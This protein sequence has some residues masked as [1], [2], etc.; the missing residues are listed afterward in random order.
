MTT[1][2]LAPRHRSTTASGPRFGDLLRSEWTKLTS[3]RSTWWS[4]GTMAGLAVGFSALASSLLTSHWDTLGPANQDQYVH[5]TIGLILQPGA[6][7]A[8]IAACVLG[9]LLFASEFS[10]G[11][12]RATVLAAPRRTPVLAAKATVFAGTLFVLAELVAVP[13]F[14]IGS[15]ITSA[16]AHT[17]IGDPGTI[18]A[19]LAFGGYIALTGVFALCVGALIR[20]PAGAISAILGLQFMLPAVCSLLPGSVGAHVAGALPASTNVM[21]GSGHNSSDVYSPLQGLL[22]LLGWTLAAYLVAR[23]TL[24]KRDV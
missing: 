22:I 20:H 10:T 19:L 1:A 21:M 3:L 14:L 16:H 11:M 4:L 24:K 15:S 17:S 23:V 18:R 7:W 12:I 8:Q 2:A 6:Q 13:S 5:D 9:V